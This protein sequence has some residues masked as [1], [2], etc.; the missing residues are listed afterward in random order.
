MT[1]SRS[2]PTALV[3]SLRPHQWIKNVLVFGGLAFTGRWHEA[4]S[5]GGVGGL[6]NVPDIARAVAAFAVFCAISSAGYLVNDIRDVA[7]DRAHPVKCRR[8][9]AAGEVSIG[10]ANFTA[11]VL[12][13]GAL[14]AAWALS[15]GREGTEFFVATAIAYAGCT[16]AYSFYLKHLVLIDVLSIGALFVLRA[17]GGCYVIP[18][19]P[20]PWIIVCTLFG[21]VFIALCKRRGE[22]VAMGDEENGK[23]RKVLRKYLAPDGPPASLLDQWINIAATCT[24][25][26]YAMYTFVR[27]MEIRLQ[28]AAHVTAETV[29]ASYEQTGLMFTIPFVVYGV[30]RYMYLVTKKDIGQS[31]ERLFTDRAMLLNLALWAVVVLCATSGR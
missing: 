22:L 5:G 9:I 26:T 20:S 2:V 25:L 27:P 12:F 30:L 13:V 14:L 10:L 17:V 23:T 8:P 31:P 29:L 18:S 11:A 1:R 28:A 16:V 7:A 6:L 24:I 21:A 19:P 15:T 4:T 3:V